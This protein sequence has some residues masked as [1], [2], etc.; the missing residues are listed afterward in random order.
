M[1]IDKYLTLFFIICFLVQW[2][3][4]G[5]EPAKLMRQK[6]LSFED[7]GKDVHYASVHQNELA[8][9]LP[10]P[11]R[12][13]QIYYPTSG[14][15]ALVVP[16]QDFFV[17]LSFE[18]EK[19]N[20]TELSKLDFEIT[21]APFFRKAP[22]GD[23]PIVKEKKFQNFFN[24]K[25]ASYEHFY[26]DQLEGDLGYFPLARDFF[27]KM[28][29][30]ISPEIKHKVVQGK[31]VLLTLTM[32]MLEQDYQ[33]RAFDLD[34]KA[35]MDGNLVFH[36]RQNHAVGPIK[37]N[38]EFVFV[39]MA[40]PQIND[41]SY[42]HRGK[43]SAPQIDLE[44]QRNALEQAV[45]E[46]NFLKP[47]FGLMGG[48]VVGGGHPHYRN[49]MQTFVNSM[50]TVKT[51]K[52]EDM[53]YWKEY[54]SYLNLIKS[55]NFP[56]FT[57]TGNHDGFA[58][59]ETMEQVATEQDFSFSGVLVGA[60]KQ[61][62]VYDGKHFFRK[63]LGP[64][65]FT[66]SLGK[67]QFVVLDTFDHFRYFRAG[68][69]SVIANHGG[70]ISSTQMNWARQVMQAAHL[71]GKK[72]VVVGHHDPRGG[73]GG[74]DYKNPKRRF[75][76]RKIKK[77]KDEI[78]FQIQEYLKDP[79]YAST[80]WSAVRVEDKKVQAKIDKLNQSFLDTH[81]GFLKKHAI[82]TYDSAKILLAMIEEYNVSHVLLGHSHADFIDRVQLGDKEVLFY[83]TTT[84]SAYAHSY[85][86]KEDYKYQEG[87][88]LGHKEHWG[89]RLFKATADG[90]LK[91]LHTLKVKES[92]H[93]QDRPSLELG[94][95]RF[96]I[97][98]NPFYDSS[99]KDEWIPGQRQLPSWMPLGKWMEKSQFFTKKYLDFL[100]SLVAQDD[101]FILH[102][103]YKEP[104]FSDFWK[105]T[106]D[107]TSMLESQRDRHYDLVS[108]Y[109]QRIKK[110][111]GPFYRPKKLIFNNRN[112]FPINGVL[113]FFVRALPGETVSLTG[114]V[115]GVDNEGSEL[116]VEELDFSFEVFPTTKGA[117]IRIPLDFPAQVES[118]KFQELGVSYSK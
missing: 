49:L 63:M 38:D 13:N 68:Y 27:L 118:K 19:F 83:H 76:R 29:F 28:N 75:P 71:A 81:N 105:Q 33:Y 51:R 109:Y 84:L 88:G 95:L 16:G 8:Q 37:S 80:D 44:R 31:T 60:E 99:K 23:W 57:T 93:E 117:I 116:G 65:Y 78:N 79:L 17:L 46:L 82:N 72:I 3:A 115:S 74:T 39:H 97:G 92:R 41:P 24:Q 25:Y 36:D 30:Q 70:W 59:Y 100:P 22:K 14:N 52:L 47:D 98:F 2:M 94:N 73:A 48:D 15:P 40:D 10:I 112:S 96:Q 87:Q 55:F 21:L 67:W 5:S 110:E 9:K 104:G 12:V 56:V 69:G 43:P 20:K 113:E 103:I 32:P 106:F 7:L 102:E 85:R 58:S 11:T 26:H 4:Y 45:K 101:P 66:F 54:T 90:S 34:I 77:L 107:Q 50:A 114:Q 108:N 42:E 62:V 1:R 111:I 53:T 35:S 89:Y 64:T 91:E 18:L 6:G 86:L 61:S